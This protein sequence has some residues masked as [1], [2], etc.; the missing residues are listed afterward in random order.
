MLLA[1]PSSF[2]ERWL[3]ARAARHHREKGV[4]F[5]RAGVVPM[6][7]GQRS[8]GR[9][10]AKRMA[11]LERVLIWAIAAMVLF[12]SASAVRSCRLHSISAPASV[13]P[14]RVNWG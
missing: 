2:A 4:W 5:I 1:V 14:S 10:A 13:V 8:S 11:T 6:R 7:S 12:W 9:R 3:H